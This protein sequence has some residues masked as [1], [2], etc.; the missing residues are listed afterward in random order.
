MLAFTHAIDDSIGSQPCHSISGRAQARTRTTRPDEHPKSSAREPLRSA[1][2]AIE[3][4][5]G[6]RVPFRQLLDGPATIQ[7]LSAHLLREAHTD[8]DISRVS[9]S[10]SPDSRAEAPK[11]A[12]SQPVPVSA[13]AQLPM[14]LCNSGAEGNG[15][16]LQKIVTQQLAIM[17][18]QLEL[19][20]GNGSGG[21]Q[22][23]FV[24]PAASEQHTV[25]ST[26]S[27]PAARGELTEAAAAERDAGAPGAD[28]AA[29]RKEPGC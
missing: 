17:Q 6:V 5:F 23:Q 13:L 21:K 20:R 2:R 24:A 11:A 1:S 22:A 16:Y 9:S 3:S 26:T 25:M 7:E 10:N 8:V 27:A 28:R 18:K 14:P 19:L 29:L 12:P 4:E 15:S